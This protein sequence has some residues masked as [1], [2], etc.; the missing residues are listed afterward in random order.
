MLCIFVN[1]AKSI[2]LALAMC[3][4][5]DKSLLFLHIQIANGGTKT[6]G[7]FPRLSFQSLDRHICN[8]KSQ[9][10]EKRFNPSAQ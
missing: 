10:E 1:C 2:L 9:N 8:I 6:I 3:K 5:V 4:C 7:H